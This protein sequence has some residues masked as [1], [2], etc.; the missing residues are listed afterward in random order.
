MKSAFANAVTRKCT[1]IV[2]EDPMYQLE[3]HEGRED[4]D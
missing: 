2:Q 3:P 1:A 4:A